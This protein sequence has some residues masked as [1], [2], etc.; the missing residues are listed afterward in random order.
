MEPKPPG[1]CYYR[2]VPFASTRKLALLLGV[3][4]LILQVTVGFACSVECARAC[5]KAA[6]ASTHSGC[7]GH[8]TAN[9]AE[10]SEHKCGG[11]CG[12]IGACDD[13]AS[14]S[15][16]IISAAEPVV[17]L[18]AILPDELL[19]SPFTSVKDPGYY[20]SDPGPPGHQFIS[21]VR[22]RA[23]PVA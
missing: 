13:K 8:G 9:K 23:P 4:G 1:V 22:S 15:Q 12:S 17:K 14:I 10:E 18:P 20:Y 7:S 5:A 11:A 6:S 2:Q 21:R 16:A 3:L 19:V